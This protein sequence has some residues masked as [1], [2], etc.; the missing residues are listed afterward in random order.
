MIIREEGLLE[1]K[2]IGEGAFQERAYL[3]DA[4]LD[5]LDRALLKKIFI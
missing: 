3:R 1:K 2:V 5:R 4:F